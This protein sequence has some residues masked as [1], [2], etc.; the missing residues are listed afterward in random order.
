MISDSKSME[1]PYFD[2]RKRSVS[3]RPVLNNLILHIHPPTIPEKTLALTHTWGLGRPARRRKMGGWSD[4]ARARTGWPLD[5]RPARQPRVVLCRR[6]RPD[7]HQPHFP[8]T[9]C[10]LHDQ[11]RNNLLPA[12]IPSLLAG[13]K[14]GEYS[15]TMPTGTIFRTGL[16]IF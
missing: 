9:L 4:R 12:A 2:A 7:R 3:R 8:A 11:D 14:E 16:Q 10:L 15:E 5:V 13:L 1:T 6:Q